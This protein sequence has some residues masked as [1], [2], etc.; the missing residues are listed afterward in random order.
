MASGF[1]L[2]IDNLSTSHVNS[3]TE[4]IDATDINNIAD[5][6]NKIETKLGINTSGP[7][8]TVALA[9]GKNL[10]RALAKTPDDLVTGA[11]TRNANGAATSAPVTWP[12]GSTGTYTTTTLSTAFLGAVDAYTVTYGNPVTE[13]Y[14]QPAPVAGSRVTAGWVYV[15]VTGLP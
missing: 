15:S 11:I 2:I 14:T 1:P 9:L 5:A 6:I 7:A 8:A 13:T 12:D 10:R 4:T 3:G